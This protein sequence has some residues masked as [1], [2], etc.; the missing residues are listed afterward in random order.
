[1]SG[2]IIRAIVDV[3]IFLA[4]Y[5]LFTGIKNPWSFFQGKETVTILTKTD[6]FWV[7]IIRI[8]VILLVNV[9]FF[10]TYSDQ[11]AQNDLIFWAYEETDTVCVLWAFFSSI[12]HLYKYLMRYR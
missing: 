8:I 7:W 6:W 11:Y 12:H 1:M 4:V 9:C 2:M 5:G 10:L 3:I